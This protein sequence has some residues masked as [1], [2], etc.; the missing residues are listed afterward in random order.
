MSDGNFGRLVDVAPRDAWAHEA[1]SFTPWLADNLEQL[2]EAIGLLLE[3]T[4]R[5]VGVGRY[6]ADIIARDPI[7]DQIVLIE[8]QLEWSDH[9]HLGQILTYLAGTNAKVIIWLAPAFREE[10]LSAIRWLNQHS[11][12]DY[13][14][15]AV[16]LRVVQIGSSPLAPLFEVLEKPNAWDRR[17]QQTVQSAAEPSAQALGRRA[18]WERYAELHPA[19]QT[20][21]VAGGGVARWRAVGDTGI[22]V[23]RYKAKDKVGLFLRGGRGVDGHAILPLLSPIADQLE[24][25]L[26]VALGKPNFPF[27]KWG[28]AIS[29]DPSTWDAAIEW[30]EAETNRYVDAILRMFSNGDAL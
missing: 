13:S 1:L 6:S 8:N 11:H 5:E 4:G 21:A 26:G 2:S 27:D 16:R 15:F 20:D 12:E 7:N 14:F 3:L 19:I 24:A 29:D 18:F 17:L 22:M 30:L 28:P 23:S 10:H 25:A 9:T